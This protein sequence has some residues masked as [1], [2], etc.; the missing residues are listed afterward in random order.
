[1]NTTCCVSKISEDVKMQI[2]E[3]I[4]KSGMPTEEFIK[5]L[6]EYYNIKKAESSISTVVLDY[7]NYWNSFVD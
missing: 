3:L 7:T 5:S 1:M 6:A 4:S 2:G